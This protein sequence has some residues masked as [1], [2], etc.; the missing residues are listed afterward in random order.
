MCCSLG[1]CS[2]GCDVGWVGVNEDAVDST[3]DDVGLRFIQLCR[4]SIDVVAEVEMEAGLKWSSTKW[5][6]VENTS[7]NMDYNER[8]MQKENIPTLQ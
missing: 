4:S 5:S 3:C 8:T 2:P 7:G 1:C 6:G